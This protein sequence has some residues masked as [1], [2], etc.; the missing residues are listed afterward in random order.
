M[1]YAMPATAPISATWQDHKNRNPPSQEP[2]TDVATAFGTRVGCAEA[3]KVTY[4]DTN[5]GG[6]EGRVVGVTLNDG[7]YVRYLHM[8]QIYVGYNQAVGRGQTLGLSGAS[9]YG[10]PWYYGPHVHVS[11]WERPGMPFSQTIDFQR[12]VGDGDGDDDMDYNTF[13]SYLQR[14]F[15]YDLRPN[16]TGTP[17]QSYTAGPTFFEANDGFG[18]RFTNLDAAVA[19][20]PTTPDGQEIDYAALAEAL[21]EAGITIAIITPTG[22]MGTAEEEGRR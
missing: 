14:A 11:L 13:L 7:R 15:K 3:G 16:G 10:D 21:K 8:D 2:G 1:G 9:G 5:P 12:Y 17:G 20:I 18:Q 6:G 19:K 4:I 22:V